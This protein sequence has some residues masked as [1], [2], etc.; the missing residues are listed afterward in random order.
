MGEKILIIE[1]NITNLKLVRLLLKIE[2]YEIFTASDASEAL[3]ILQTVHPKLILMDLQLPGKN[4]LDLTKEIKAD[5]K[6]KDIV[7]IALTAYAMKGDEE[8]AKLAGCDEY[9]TKPISVDNFPAVIAEYM[10]KYAKPKY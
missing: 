10:V 9:M 1:D 5:P 6:L 8:K 3:H 7:I 4:G 2:G